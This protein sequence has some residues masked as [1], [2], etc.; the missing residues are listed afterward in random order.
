MMTPLKSM[1]DFLYSQDWPPCATVP[2]GAKVTLDEFLNQ[3]AYADS[4][5]VC[6]ADDSCQGVVGVLT[7]EGVRALQAAGVCMT[8]R[9][10][11]WKPIRLETLRQWLIT[12][13]K[14]KP[15]ANISHVP[16]PLDLE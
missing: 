12:D 5:L 16:S 10:H 6:L 3:P 13:G 4:C 14:L 1:A 9:L 2:D 11:Y 8:L 7:H 15:A